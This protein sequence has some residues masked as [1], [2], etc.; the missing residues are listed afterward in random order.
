MNKSKS[1]AR[2]KLAWYENNKDF[3]DP[4]QV[5]LEEDFD[6]RVFGVPDE[7]EKKILDFK[8][9]IIVFDYRMPF[10]SGIEMFKKLKKKKLRFIPVFYTIWAKDDD[11][12]QKIKAA[13]IDEDAIVDKH[14]ECESF[15]KKITE[16]FHGRRTQWLV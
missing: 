5:Y 13:G 4:I 15:A 8:P 6:I 2:P 7:A 1:K 14:M 12:R 9:D 11:S 3:T 16:Y 10:I